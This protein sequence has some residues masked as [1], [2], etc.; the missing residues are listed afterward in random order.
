MRRILDFLPITAAFVWIGAAHA[1]P[2]DEV[3]AGLYHCNVIADDRQWLDCFYGAA[4]PVR[5]ALRLE[6]VLPG[7]QALVSHPPPGT[8]PRVSAMRSRIVADAGS[9]YARA[10]D[11]SWLDCYYAAALPLRQALK[12]PVSPVVRS[13]AGR[14]DVQL[15][16]V[17]AVRMA[18][19]RFDAHRIFTVTLANGQTWRQ[20]DGDVYAANWNKAAA[21]YVVDIKPGAFGSH[22]LSVHGQPHVFKVEQVR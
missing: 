4:Q 15:G 13:V 7:Q 6:P 19:Y 16:Y 9:C 18:S 11:R 5:A 21:N 1:A 17:T 12:L 14:S 20:L 2:R 22:N 8:A 10:G 3:M